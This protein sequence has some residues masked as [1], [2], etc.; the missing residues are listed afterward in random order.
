MM[1][2]IAQ[3][4]SI[5]RMIEIDKIRRVRTSIYK[6]N[7][8]KNVTMATA[9]IMGWSSLFHEAVFVVKDITSVEGMVLVPCLAFMYTGLFITG[10]DAMHGTVTRNPMI[11]D[12]IGHV[13]T[14]LYAGF[15]FNEMRRKH[16]LHHLNTGIVKDD[17]DFH[18]GNPN[19]YAWFVSFM[20]EYFNKA[21]VF[22]LILFV[23]VLKYNGAPDE[24]IYVYMA[25]CGL[26]SSIQLFYFGTY[27]PHRPPADT[28]DEVMNWEK[29]KSTTKTTRLESFLTCFHF[30]CHFEHHA[31]PQVP[32]FELWDVKKKIED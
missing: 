16:M 4:R 13:C 22:K 9:V 27:I 17:P 2:R 21:Q 28:L 20:L 24:N 25:L 7:D 10:H 5:P 29:S 8:I 3:H 30:D 6:P 14:N 32:W 1:K 23:E 11:N 15:D 18:K 12:M 26:L 19:V 31:L